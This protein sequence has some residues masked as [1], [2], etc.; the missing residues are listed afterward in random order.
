MEEIARA[1]GINRALIYRCFS[2]RE[3]LYVRTISRY[4]DEITAQ[5]LARIDRSDPLPEQLRASWT[6]F[7][8]YCLEHPAFV[9]CAT[10]LMRRPAEELRAV[11]GDAAWSELGTAMARGLDVT[12]AIIRE[13]AAAG[14]FSSG[15]PEFDDQP[16]LRPDPG[17]A[18][19][20]PARHRRDAR[21]GGRPEP[22]RDRR[23][24][25][26]EGVRGRRAVGRRRTPAGDL[27][28]RPQGA[29]AHSLRP[30]ACDRPGR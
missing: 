13:G 25:G 21:R 14:V 15:N 5:G 3:E 23:S 26:A 30:G 1:A 17:P 10:S 27:S 28:H 18:P 24:R 11:L 6:S 20:R 29:A 4:L 19:Q 8:D 22:V 16:S 12:A 2:S 9:D 7:V